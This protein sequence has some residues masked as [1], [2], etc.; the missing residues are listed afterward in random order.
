MKKFKSCYI[1]ITN[2]CNLNCS[3]CPK[4]NREKRFMTC[5]EYKRVIDQI[6][7]FCN[8]VYLHLMG[9]PLMHPHLEEILKVSEEEK[10][11]TNITTNGTLLKNKLDAL[12]NASALRKVSISAHSFE[13]N[14]NGKNYEEYLKGIGEFSI[15]FSDAGKEV[16]IKF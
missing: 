14:E 10:I 5:D 8:Y 15:K 16:V 12:L 4:T 13:A 11:K 9:E 7:P 1:E 2:N 3:F 6:K